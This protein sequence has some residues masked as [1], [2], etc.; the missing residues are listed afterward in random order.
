MASLPAVFRSAMILSYLEGFSNA[1][2][3]HLAGVE[4]H[5]I[6]SLLVR[7]RELMQEEFIAHLR[8]YDH[9]H[10]GADRTV[11]PLGISGSAEGPFSVESVRL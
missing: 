11:A 2:I 10:A 4:P 9:A 6:E 5:A 7:G 1:E 8:S 3:A